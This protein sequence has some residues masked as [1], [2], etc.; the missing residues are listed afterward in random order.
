M[1]MNPQWGG[2]HAWMGAVYEK[3]NQCSAAIGEYSRAIELDPNG[4][5]FDVVET[6]RRID[7]LRAKCSG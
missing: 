2:P 6:Q 5:E 7:Q 1:E 4:Y 3:K